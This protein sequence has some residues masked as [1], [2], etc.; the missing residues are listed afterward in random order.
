MKTQDD[1]RFHF[2]FFIRRFILGVCLADQR[3]HG[4]IDPSARLDY[5]WDEFLFRLFIEI[6]ERLAAC[7]LMLR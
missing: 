1:T 4:A 5:V 7:L 2:T 3:E 6:F